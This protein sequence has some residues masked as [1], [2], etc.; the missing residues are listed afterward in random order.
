M[1]S[2]I[3]KFVLF[4]AFTAGFAT[5][6]V[7]S[8]EYPTPENS[9]V[10]YEFVATKSVQEIK[11]LSLL[12]GATPV[13]YGADDIIEGYVTSNDKES[14]F[15]NTISLQTI[16]TDGSQPI[17][18]SITANFRAF[19]KGF[20]P[21]RK[22]YIKLNGLYTA[23]VDGS[24]KI[25][26]LY[27]GSI[28]RISE[29]EWQNYIFPSATLVGENSFVTN[30]SLAEAANDALLNRLVE[31]ENVQFV[32]E[33]L[34]R[35]Y[36]D[37]DS[38][39]GATN[40]NI[41]STTGGA[42]KYFRVSSFAPFSKKQVASGS[43][44]IRGVMTKYGSDFQFLVRD[45]TDIKLNS[46]RVSIHAPLGGT[47]IQFNGSFSEAFTS[48]NLST[49]VFPKYIND[50]TTGNRYWQLKQYPTG[51][52]NKY[53][54]MSSFGGGGVTAKTYFFVPI[55]FSAAS[56]FTFKKEIRY[57]TGEVLKVFYVKS[58][59]YTAGGPLNLGSFVDI[60]STFSLSY[61]AIGSSDN[62]FTTAGTYN[63][64]ATLTGTGFFVFQYS[65]T[66]TVT[67]TMQLDDITAN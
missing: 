26:S 65:G 42:T 49:T 15:Y 35:T 23:F 57:N 38:G 61:P 56:T 31:I 54:E 46:A 41:I 6:C 58:A 32:D 24:L 55:D 8:D 20:V 59:D 22:A 5:S 13:L 63:I 50:Q 39:G 27:N 45:E 9:L 40:H 28:G 66:P 11:T 36:Y 12:T 29:N 53:I 21:G 37:V 44:K 2:R 51:T 7:N 43:G 1:K 25:G 10:T 60:T 34:S 62:S 67:T 4:V 48:Y 17:G 16:P 30:L 52:G 19:A 33:S 3:I 64:P 14:N 18:F 47:D